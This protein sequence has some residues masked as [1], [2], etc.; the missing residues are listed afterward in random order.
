MKKEEDPSKFCPYARCCKGV[1]AE[2]SS[3]IKAKKT[4]EEMWKEIKVAMSREH[5]LIRIKEYLEK[6]DPDHPENIN[7]SLIYKW[8]T[9][10]L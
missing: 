9:M 3:C 7:I 2:P 8:A 6:I 1:C 10:G 4:E 5:R